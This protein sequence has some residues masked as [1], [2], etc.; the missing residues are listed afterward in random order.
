MNKI[1]KDLTPKLSFH[2]SNN[3]KNWDIFYFEDIF[4]FL[5][6]NAL[7][8][9]CMNNN[10]GY[11][12]N[13]HYGDILTKYNTILDDPSQI[14]YINSD[15]IISKYDK[16]SYITNGDVII[17]DTAE[18]FTAGKA[19]EVQ[20]VNC[21]ILSGLHTFLCRPK[22]KIAQMYLGY[23]LNSSQYH[24]KLI[25]LLT[26]T[27]VYS[28]NK[29]NISKTLVAIP[30]AIEEQEKIAECLKSIDDL[31]VEQEAKLEQLKAHKKGLLQK[32]FP[33]REGCRPSLRFPQFLQKWITKTLEEICIYKNGGSYENDI[34]ENGKYNLITLNSIDSEGNL[35]K[36]HRLINSVEW[37]LQKNDIVM[38][39][40]DV[41]TGN[42]LGLSAVIPKNNQYVLNQRMG[43][44]RVKPNYSANYL[45]YY[46]NQNQKYFKF[47]GQGANQKNLSKK[48]ILSFSINIPINIDEQQKIADCLSS[49]DELISAQSE[50]IEALKQ[51]KKGLMQGLFPFIEEVENE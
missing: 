23:Y 31:I 43:L 30:K 15:V 18:D 4:D 29:M 14:P 11:L 33:E 3:T 44:L 35:K 20:N 45:R 5:K 37:F 28:I 7:P 1:E 48:D 12:K 22:F 19:I 32:L 6:T 10:K 46:I 41:A 17:A 27:K 16:D 26:G 51:H 13:I 38:V 40:S 24:K 25:K 34:I 47:Y 8:R 50:K 21:E 2:V 39:L 9:N 36:E 42:F 49:V